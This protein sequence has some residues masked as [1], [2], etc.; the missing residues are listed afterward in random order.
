M[1]RGRSYN[2]ASGDALSPGSNRVISIQICGCD[3]HA[4]C[5]DIC[6][7][8]ICLQLKSGCLCIHKA[9]CIC[10]HC[11]SQVMNVSCHSAFPCITDFI[12]GLN[13][14]TTEIRQSTI[15]VHLRWRNQSV[16]CLRQLINGLEQKA[17][18]ESDLTENRFQANATIG[19]KLCNGC[20]HVC[21]DLRWWSCT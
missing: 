19:I 1:Q 11:S 9:R 20:F 18:E 16:E 13:C 12:P 17:E 3:M 14:L 21:V 6:L 2:G 10:S 8:S 7:Q 4:A 5:D 15:A